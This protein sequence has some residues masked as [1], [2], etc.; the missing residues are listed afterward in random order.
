MRV[1]FASAC[2]DAILFRH[3]AGSI[4]SGVRGTSG[5]ANPF[6]LSNAHPKSSPQ[7]VEKHATQNRDRFHLAADAVYL[8]KPS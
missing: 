3:L 4:R 2:P 7:S 1:A 6:R 8:A 5:P